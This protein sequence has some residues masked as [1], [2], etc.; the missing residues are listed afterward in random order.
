MLVMQENIAR[1]PHLGKYVIS[2]PVKQQMLAQP[3]KPIPVII[4]AAEDSRHPELGVTTAKAVLKG[5]LKS[6]AIDAKESDFYLFATLSPDQIS[7][8]AELKEVRQIWKDDQ[9]QAHL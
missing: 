2:P 9:T 4:C 1:Q 3:E 6:L 7:K 5:W 8:L